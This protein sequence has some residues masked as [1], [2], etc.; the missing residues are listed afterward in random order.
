MK[1]MMR[2]FAFVA[3]AALGFAAAPAQ[4]LVLV[5]SDTASHANSTTNWTDILTVDKYSG[6]FGPL[7]QVKI[8][9]SGNVTGSAEYE[10]LDNSPANISIDLAATITLTLGGPPIVQVIPLA[11]V[12]ANPAAHDGDVDFAGPSGGSFPNLSASDMDMVILNDLVNL[13]LF[14]GPG[15]INLMADGVG[16]SE[17][18]GAGNLLLLFATEAGADVTVEYYV[19]TVIP[20]PAALPAGLGLLG[21]AAIRRRRNG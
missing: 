6:A 3:V 13:A 9:L 2:R 16:T 21:L 10:S 8:T 18:S 5:E 4:A 15:T 20:L 14:T 7:V 1:K 11:N 12:M 19:D 17:G